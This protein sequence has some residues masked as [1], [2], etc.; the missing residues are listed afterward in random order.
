MKMHDYRIVLPAHIPQWQIREFGFPHQSS[1]LEGVGV[2]EI[3]EKTAR[4]IIHGQQVNNQ[5]FVCPY[6]CKNGM[7]VYVDNSGYDCPIP[8]PNCK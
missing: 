7:Y 1:E 4:T 3:K 6:R 2:A 5:K 8:C